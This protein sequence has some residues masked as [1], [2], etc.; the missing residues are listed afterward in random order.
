MRA[1]ST[2]KKSAAR[3]VAA[4]ARRKARPGSVMPRWRRDAV[5]AQ[6]LA[7]GGGS[8]PMPEPVQ[9]A[10][11]PDHAPPGVLP[12]Q[13][14]D[15]RDELLRDRRAS[16]RP[17]LTPLHRHQA[18]VPAQERAGRHDPPGPQPLRHD[19]GERGEHGPV[20]PGHARSGVGPAQHGDLVPQHEYL[21]VLGRRG[22]GQQREPGQHGHQQPVSQRDTH[23]CRSCRCRRPRSNQRPSIRPLQVAIVLGGPPSVAAARILAVLVTIAASFL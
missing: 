7:D 16:R 14:H 18:P 9:L 2:W 12:R 10:L 13:A 4:W 22:P 3:S 15:Q 8:H 5:G 19:P 17:G 6:D 20:G 21:R 23:G 11:D 1:Q